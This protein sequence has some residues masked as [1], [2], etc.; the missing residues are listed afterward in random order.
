[1]LSAYM[2]SPFQPG[3]GTSRLQ[4]CG[5]SAVNPAT[6]AAIA[7]PSSSGIAEGT[8]NHRVLRTPST[9]MATAC[10]GWSS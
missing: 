2:H 9:A 5:K 3:A 4:S 10:G 8:P 6:T 7:A 1:M